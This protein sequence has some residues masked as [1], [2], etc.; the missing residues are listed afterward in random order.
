MPNAAIPMRAQ[1]LKQAK[2]DR[3][4]FARLPAMQQ[5]FLMKEMREGW[6][7]IEV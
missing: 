3:K 5:A 6:G 7:V 1:I 2:R 4:A